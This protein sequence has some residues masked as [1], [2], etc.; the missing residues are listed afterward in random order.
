MASKS[1]C[2]HFATFLWGNGGGG[3]GGGNMV[4]YSDL[5]KNIIPAFISRKQE[6]NIK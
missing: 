4:G 1:A 2:L 5:K 6:M 3:G